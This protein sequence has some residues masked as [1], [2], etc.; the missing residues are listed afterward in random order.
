M[1]VQLFPVAEVVLA[2]QEYE[3]KITPQ[4]GL[5]AQTVLHCQQKRQLE[6]PPL[7]ENRQHTRVP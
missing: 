3:V 4:L 1:L 7:V 2:Q 6:V 5:D